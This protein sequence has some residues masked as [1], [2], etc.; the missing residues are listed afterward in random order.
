MPAMLQEHRT[1]LYLIMHGPMSGPVPRKDLIEALRDGLGAC[2]EVTKCGISATFRPGACRFDIQKG[3]ALGFH[4]PHG[5][6][7]SRNKKEK[8]PDV[9]PE[10]IARICRKGKELADFIGLSHHATGWN[11]AAWRALCNKDWS[12]E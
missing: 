10:H 12:R 1:T 4:R 8:R 3:T 11:G 6:K 9:V 7:G 5:G 2:V